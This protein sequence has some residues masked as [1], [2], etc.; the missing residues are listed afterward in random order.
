[1]AK[2]TTVHTCS[3]CAHQTARWSGRCPGCGDWNT[4]VEERAPTATAARGAA[5]AP[6][7]PLRLAD[8][9]TTPVPR[10][11]TGIGE[12]DRVLGGGSVPGSL[13]LLGGSPGIG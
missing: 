10:L 6:G 3:N 8:V 11:R 1:M 13:V 9:D 2:P 7:R 12:F 4:L 5:K